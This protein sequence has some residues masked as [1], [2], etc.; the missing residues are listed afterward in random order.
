MYN[1]IDNKYLINDK[2]QNKN[3]TYNKY[4]KT[5]V[6]K[7]FENNMFSDTIEKAIFWSSELLASGYINDLYNKLLYFYINHVNKVNINLI[8]IFHKELIYFNKIKDTKDYDYK[9]TQYF[10]NHIAYM[11]CLVTFSTKCKLPKIPTID[12]IYFNMKNN[13][14]LTKDLTSIKNFITNDDNKN[15]I[16]PLSEI[17]FNLNIKNL[18]KSL[19]NCLFWLNWII[20]YEKNFHKNNMQCHYSKI[21]SKSVSEKCKCDFTWIIWKI[22]FNIS[23]KINNKYINYLYDLYCLN[24]TKST[25]TKK[26][27][28]II[29]AFLIIIDPIPKINY[30]EPI[31]TEKNKIITNQIIL[32]INLQYQDLLNNKQSTKYLQENTHTKISPFFSKDQFITH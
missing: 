12:P 27:N 2:K 24:F 20:I 18:T 13:K 31:L 5:E 26:I 25:K 1:V 21:D 23:D 7:D 15:I 8:E 32:S 4:K 10:R 9:N 17:L 19:E 16:I 3:S 11:T 28:I 29:F 22:I 14:L 6:L 30:T